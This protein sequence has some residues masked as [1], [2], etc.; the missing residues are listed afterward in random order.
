MIAGTSRSGSNIARSLCP[1]RCR[2]RRGGRRRGRRRRADGR[3]ARGARSAYARRR[4]GRGR[5]GPSPHECAALRGRRPPRPGAPNRC[6]RRRNCRACDSRR[7]SP[8][9]SF[10]LTNN[11]EIGCIA[12][13]GLGA[14]DHVRFEIEGLRPPHIAYAAKPA[15]HFASDEQHLLFPEHRPDLREMG[16][17][18]QNGAPAPITGS[19]MNA[20]TVS[21]PSARISALSASA[22]RVANSSSLSPSS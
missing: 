13:E 12:A 20:A 7:A 5:R 9:G 14:G 15:D 3:R 22:M 8:G 18:R 11:A 2:G 10:S 21:G 1:R 19:A 17:G 16:R 6:S 4:V